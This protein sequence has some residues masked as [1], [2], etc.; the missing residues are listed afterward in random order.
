MY[1][2]KRSRVAKKL[3]AGKDYIIRVAKAE[4]E[5]SGCMFFYRYQLSRN[6]HAQKIHYPCHPT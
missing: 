5:D 2:T 6:T 3:E 1:L 4:I